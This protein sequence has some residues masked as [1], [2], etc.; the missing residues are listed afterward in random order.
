MALLYLGTVI[1]ASAA[2]R[3]ADAIQIVSVHG[4]GGGRGWS[5]NGNLQVLELS[6]LELSFDCTFLIALL[7]LLLLL[8]LLLQQLQH[9]ASTSELWTS[10]SF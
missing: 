2:R 7:L 6:V 5:S 8:M 1:S 9:V 3:R 10:T 4:V